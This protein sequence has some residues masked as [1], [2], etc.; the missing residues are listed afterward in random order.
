M[1]QLSSVFKLVGAAAISTLAM[2]AF[3]NPATVQTGTQA[4]TINGDNNQVIQVINQITIDHPGLGRGR[5]NNDRRATVQN[6]YQGAA[7]DGSG[8]VVYQESNQVNSGERSGNP[9]RRVGQRQAV[10]GRY[11]DDDDD[12]PRGRSHRQD[13]DD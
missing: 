11:D 1:K 5:S 9:G 6:T 7:I 10:E 8:N 2:P 12:Q 13:Q 4:A 3:A